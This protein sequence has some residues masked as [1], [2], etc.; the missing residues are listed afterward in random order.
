MLLRLLFYKLLIATCLIL[1]SQACIK[2]VSLRGS[3]VDDDGTDKSAPAPTPSDQS[4]Q[5]VSRT[6]EWDANPEEETIS[7][8][9]I[10]FGTEEDNYNGNCV[11]NGEIS[12]PLVIDVDDLENSNAPAYIL[13]DVRGDIVCYFAV[14]A[15]RGTE[16]SSL[17]ESVNDANL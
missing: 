1:L 13:E 2:K 10:Y 17:S 9:K 8:Y 16:E 5:I 7:G 11:V 4:A 3:S 15:F 12:S 6:I 14:S